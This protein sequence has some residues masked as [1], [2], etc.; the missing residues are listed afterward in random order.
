MAASFRRLR[1]LLHV[2]LQRHYFLGVPLFTHPLKHWKVSGEEDV[3]AGAVE[4]KR[5]FVGP[6][7]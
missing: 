3:A 5:D 7:F 2:R 1:L 4:F 6:R